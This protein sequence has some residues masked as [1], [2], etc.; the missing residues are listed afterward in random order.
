MVSTMEDLRERFPN[1]TAIDPDEAGTVLHMHA[2]H[3][4]RLLR[5]G[6]LPGTKIGARWFI[7]IGKLAAILDGDAQMP[8]DADGALR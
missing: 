3:V 1:Q 2:G 5:E 6:A 8:T 7:P 4:R